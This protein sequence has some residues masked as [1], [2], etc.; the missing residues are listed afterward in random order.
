M[1]RLQPIV[2]AEAHEIIKDRAA[3]LNISISLAAAQVIEAGI[4]A[5]YGV[6]VEPPNP[7]GDVSRIKRMAEYI[8]CPRCQMWNVGTLDGVKYCADCGWSD[9]ETDDA[10]K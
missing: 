6:Q 2:S 7:H 10:T 5:L 9:K 4:L 8:Q 3:D 1:P